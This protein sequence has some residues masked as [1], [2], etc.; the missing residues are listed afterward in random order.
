MRFSSK[1]AGFALLLV[2]SVR[3]GKKRTRLVAARAKMVGLAPPWC[4]LLTDSRVG[5]RG[6]WECT[7]SRVASLVLPGVPCVRS[8]MGRLQPV[9]RRTTRRS[10]IL[11]HTLATGDQPSEGVNEKAWVV[12]AVGDHL[13]VVGVQGNVGMRRCRSRA[14]H[15]QQR[16][17]EQG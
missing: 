15:R 17:H 4:G 14:K 2:T 6:W 1:F 9:E 3:K 11:Q 12:L 16:R 10:R 8:V 5:G 13:S 7:L